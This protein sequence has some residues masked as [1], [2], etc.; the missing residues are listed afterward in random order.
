MFRKSTSYVDVP[1]FSI[2]LKSSFCNIG[3]KQ[4]L[5]GVD[6]LQVLLQQKEIG[7]VVYTDKYWEPNI[8][9]LGQR[10]RQ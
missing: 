2:R 6:F 3:T 7:E 5:K 10:E 8:Q 9:K 4:L 1:Y